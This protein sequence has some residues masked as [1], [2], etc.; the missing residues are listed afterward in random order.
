MGNSSKE[1]GGGYA[2]FVWTLVVIFVVYLFS[3]QTGYAIINVSMGKDVGLD[4]RQ[5][6]IIAAVYTW[7]F[8]LFQFYGGAL[9][10]Q[11]GSRKVIPL[12]I[13]LVTLGAFIFANAHSYEMLLVS[14]VVLAIG[15]CVGFVGAGYVGGKWFGMAK[16]SFM[17][18]LVQVVASFTSAISQNLIDLTLKYMDW[19]AL[20]TWVGA[21]GVL[22]TILGAMFIRNPTPV[23]STPGL[24]VFGFLKAVTL[25][26]VEV[27][28][29]PHTWMAG[30]I[31]AGTFGVLLSLG[32]VWAPKLLIVRG[33]SPSLAV[34]GAS[35]LWLGL[36]AGSLVVPWW[37]DYLKNR[38]LPILLGAIIQLITFS[39][40]VYV[41]NLGVELDLVLCFIFGF[42]N[43]S[44]MLSFSTAAD[45]VQ[46]S[47]I[48][49]SAAVVNGLM[50]I[51]G[52]LMIDAPGMR[53][54]QG[55]AEGI[56]RGTM[57]MVAFAG[58]P[59]VV[60]L[61]IATVLAFLIKETYP[62]S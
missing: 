3:I 19:R 7:V 8:A 33:A 29:I 27:A 18:G 60:V 9:L 56:P 51:V 61:A 38:K 10:D 46:P 34:F 31:G 5:I 23:E 50:F 21:F 42:A 28:K 57:E 49:T 62:K 25:K 15:S 30:L 44:H 13:G 35:L 6:G 47:Q 20:F 48:G 1:L 52:G 37:S 41:P 4:A 32:V 53:I 11:L 55:I 36:T 22:L 12:C 26:L 14:Q 54:G 17:F 45:V 24:G 2:W 59:L 16:F 40:L 43:A 39:L 58:L